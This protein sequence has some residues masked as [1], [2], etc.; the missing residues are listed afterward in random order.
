[1]RIT[2]NPLRE[3]KNQA[4][5]RKVASQLVDEFVESLDREEAQMGPDFQFDRVWEYAILEL[6]DWYED[7]TVRSTGEYRDGDLRLEK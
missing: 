7:F 4:A 6:A 3:D 2:F 5:H 1:M